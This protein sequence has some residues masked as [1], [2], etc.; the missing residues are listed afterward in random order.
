MSPRALIPVPVLLAVIA[1][2]PTPAAAAV[3][4]APGIG[5]DASSLPLAAPGGDVAYLTRAGKR[6]T[7]LLATAP[8][9]GPAVRRL[10]IPGHLALPAVAYDGLPGGLSADGR[11][12]IL[13]KPRARFPRA[14]T[15]LAVVDP[16]RM[17]MRR[18][19]HLRGDF[20]FDAISPDGRLLYLI[21]YLSKRDITD[22]AVRA[23]DMRAR[24]LFR[25]PVVDPSEPDEDMSGEP[26]SRVTDATGRW[27][28]TLYASEEHPFVH[29]LDTERRTA[30]CIDLDIH[31]GQALA[32]RGDRLD[33]LGGEQILASIDTSTHRVIPAPSKR[34]A[35]R[36]S[37]TE[38]AAGFPWLLIAGPTAALMLLAALG[39]RRSATRTAAP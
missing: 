18:Q 24:R 21:Q 15:T 28:Y 38:E 39:R 33:V 7:R 19:I 14:N 31:G 1:G 17:R 36:R 34:P 30:V 20:S 25:Q 11:T 35:H 10:R 5:L 3:E 13:I 9:G 29:A 27:A 26:L 32:M 16:T 4:K 37:A 12:L 8:G 22:Y 23:Y 6:S 2:V